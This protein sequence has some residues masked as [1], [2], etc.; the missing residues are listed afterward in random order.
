M[1]REIYKYNRSGL[2]N[3]STGEQIE[4][5]QPVFGNPTPFL[6]EA[7]IP[8]NSSEH[9]GEVICMDGNEYSTRWYPYMPYRLMHFFLLN[10]FCE[11][12]AIEYEISF[13]EGKI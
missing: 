11:G 9:T 7:Q 3:V 10:G 13:I 4:L 5:R 12:E 1:N 8:T 6:F 2:Y